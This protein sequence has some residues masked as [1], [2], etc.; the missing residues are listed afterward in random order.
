M[1]EREL[2]ESYEYKQK[3]QDDEEYSKPQI[4]VEELLKLNNQGK[5]SLES[6]DDQ[7]FVIIFAVNIA[8]FRCLRK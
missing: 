3:L 4:F 8:V 6:L 7:I 1:K 5:I 2:K